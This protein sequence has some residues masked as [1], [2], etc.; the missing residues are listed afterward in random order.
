MKRLIIIIFVFQTGF[1]LSQTCCT[2]GTP[3]LGSLEMSVTNKNL[4]QINLNFNYNSLRDIYDRDIKLNDNTRERITQSAILELNYGLTH[5]ITLTSLF[6]Y[7][8]QVRII[9]PLIGN[10]NTLVTQGFGDI[11]LLA[12][13]NF[14]QQ[15]ILSKNDITA[16]LGVKLPIGKSSV[17]QNN[18][19][20][21]AD[22]QP[23]TGSWDIIFWAYYSR[24][25]FLSLP[26]NAILNLSYKLNGSNKRFGGQFGNYKFGNE[27]ISTTGIVYFYN[28]IFTPTFFLRIR[29][30]TNDKFSNEE[31]PNTGG[32]WFYFIPAINISFSENIILRA[33]A[34]IPVYRY[35]NGVQLTTTLIGSFS[36]IY[37]I[38]T[39][40]SPSI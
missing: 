10:N 22:L 26:V 24:A 32:W 37:R 13:Y 31:I 2:S 30:T 17:K 38:N 28:K 6:S 7:V 3:L 23:G 16:G 40:S 34:Q 20:V 19:L 4:L 15:N 35:L 1:I 5:K 12:K 29:N 39:K 36:V 8:K 33:D 21:P 27:F 18:I 25:N 14:I 11:I 9:S